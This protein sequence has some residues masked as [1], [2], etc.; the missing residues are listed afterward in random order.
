MVIVDRSIPDDAF[1]PQQ[2]MEEVKERTAVPP[3]VPI[4]P[5]PRQTLDNHASTQ[6]Q[7]RSRAHEI[8]TARG[9]TGQCGTGL[10]KGGSRD[11]QTTPRLAH[12]LTLQRPDRALG[13]CSKSIG[14]RNGINA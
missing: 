7:I 10:E 9:K 2:T 8:Y 14:F 13:Q 1:A 3:N 5:P 12:K 4:E 11:T 6:D